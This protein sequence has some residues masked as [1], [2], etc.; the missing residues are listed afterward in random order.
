MPVTCPRFI[1]IEEAHIEGGGKE[2]TVFLLPDKKIAELNG[3][4]AYTP[5]PVSLKLLNCS[6]IKEME[7]NYC[8]MLQEPEAEK[9]ICDQNP[10]Y[11][12]FYIARDTIA[13]LLAFVK[14][15]DYDSKK[16]KIL[17]EFYFVAE[18]LGITTD[19]RCYIFQHQRP[20]HYNTSIIKQQHSEINKRRKP[21]FSFYLDSFPMKKNRYLLYINGGYPY[22]E[23]KIQ[24]TG[25]LLNPG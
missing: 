14:Y 16:D 17:A 21:R 11:V 7:R 12:F 10:G 24:D 18:W 20:L 9:K 3:I 4:Y 1:H 23:F 15:S 22:F 19:I 25:S 5:R 8:A 6:N 2:R 13:Y